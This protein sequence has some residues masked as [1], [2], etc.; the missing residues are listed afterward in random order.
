MQESRTQAAKDVEDRKKTASTPTKRWPAR[1]LTALGRLREEKPHRQLAWKDTPGVVGRRHGTDVGTDSD[2]LKENKNKKSRHTRIF[3]CLVIVLFIE[4]SVGK[5]VKF[6]L[7]FIYF[8]KGILTSSHKL[9]GGIL[10]QYTFA[11]PLSP[12]RSSTMGTHSQ[13]MQAQPLLL[14]CSLSGG[15]YQPAPAQRHQAGAP[16]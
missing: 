13:H 11:Q 2:N 10:Q 16:R 15:V 5:S 6:Y 1:L 4:V 14:R 8:V 3:F 9:K 12:S 7:L